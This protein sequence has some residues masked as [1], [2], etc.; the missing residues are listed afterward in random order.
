MQAVFHTR[1]ERIDF[2][3]GNTETSGLAFEKN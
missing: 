1:S 2:S 3:I